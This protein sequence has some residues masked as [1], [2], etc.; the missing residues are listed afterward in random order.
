VPQLKPKPPL[1]RLKAERIARGWT[2]LELAFRSHVPVSELSR[3]E[4]GQ[5][6][7]YPKH[8]FRLAEALEI[9]E[10]EL[11]REPK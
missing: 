8:A 11:F 10:E 4:T 3:I 6:K 9:S 1:L 2:Q 7:P 5:S